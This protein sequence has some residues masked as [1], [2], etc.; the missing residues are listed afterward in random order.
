MNRTLLLLALLTGCATT[1]QVQNLEKKVT[2]LEAKVTELEKRPAGPAGA[3]PID[4]AKEE[5]AAAAFKEIDELAKAGK[6]EEASGKISAFAAAHGTTQTYKRAKKTL[7]ELA[8]VGKTVD[9]QWSAKIEKWYQGEGKVD[10]TKGTTL[11]VFWEE[12]CPHCKR[13][14]PKL[15]ETYGKYQGKGLNVVGLTRITKSSTE[16][17]VTAFLTEQKVNYPVAKENGK[18]AEDFAIG[19]IPAAAVVKDGK[20]VWRGHPAKLDDAALT[21]ILGG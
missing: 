21:Q 20:V 18:L 10:L 14:V 8:V 1:E 12:W 9:P 11:V 5:A 13:E 15:V 2:D 17:K 19:G 4:P 3:A 6:Y 16:E 7:D